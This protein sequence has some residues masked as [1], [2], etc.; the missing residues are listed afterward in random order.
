MKN[1]KFSHWF[2]ITAVT[3]TVVFQ[4]QIAECSNDADAKLLQVGSLVWIYQSTPTIYIAINMKES[5][6]R[7]AHSIESSQHRNYLET[8]ELEDQPEFST[9]KSVS[10]SRVRV[11]V[12]IKY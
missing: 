9:S 1:I 7:E 10:V 3:V 11:E 6:E 8:A 12:S 5:S 2:W 4:G